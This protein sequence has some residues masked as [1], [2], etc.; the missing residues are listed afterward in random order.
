MFLKRLVVLYSSL[1][2]LVLLVKGEGDRVP[3]NADIDQYDDPILKEI[4]HRPTAS[5][6][7]A[8]AAPQIPRASV[9]HAQPQLPQPEFTHSGDN[10]AKGYS[11]NQQNYYG[12]QT[13]PSIP[14]ANGHHQQS[15][16]GSLP[17]GSQ[18]GFQQPTY[19]GAGA[20]QLGSLAIQG[21]QTFYNGLQQA[22]RAF[23]IQPAQYDMPFANYAGGLFG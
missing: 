8:A 18:F 9:A 12:S 2:A 22:G 6:V 16:P 7:D 19:G 4:F 3:S 1:S 10:G 5:T 20:D 15:F 14:S 23:G 21:A 13:P 17:Q 11:Q